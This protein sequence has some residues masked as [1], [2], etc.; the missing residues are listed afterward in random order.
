MYTYDINIHI[1]AMYD[2]AYEYKKEQIRQ[3]K[4]TGDGRIKFA[5]S[6]FFLG[7]SA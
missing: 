4:R 6:F 5:K 1:H 3:Q 7:P 2:I